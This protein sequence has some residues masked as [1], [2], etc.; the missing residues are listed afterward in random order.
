[1]NKKCH[2]FLFDER[3]PPWMNKTIKKLIHEKKTFSIAS[4]KMITISSYWV[5]CKIFKHN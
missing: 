2:S 3:D 4:V 1:M 5:D